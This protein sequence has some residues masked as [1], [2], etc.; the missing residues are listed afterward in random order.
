MMVGDGVNDV[1]VLVI[2]DIG[3]FMG[4]GFD[5]LFEIVD[6]IFMNNKIE[7]IDKIFR[8]LKVN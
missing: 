7:N 5:V 4:S 1:L 8:I 2:V 6:I 3:V